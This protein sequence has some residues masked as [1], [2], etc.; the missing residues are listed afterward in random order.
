L[1]P[2]LGKSLSRTGLGEE[3]AEALIGVGGL[4]LLCEITVGLKR[5][6]TSVYRVC[7]HRE[8]IATHLDAMFE[9]VQL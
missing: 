5:A 2:H 6:D 7:M 9:A 4:A 8:E 1:F 3:G